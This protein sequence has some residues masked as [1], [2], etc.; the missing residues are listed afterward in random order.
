MGVRREHDVEVVACAHRHIGHP[1][2]PPIMQNAD[3]Q[4][5]HARRR[6]SGHTVWGEA[7]SPSV[8]D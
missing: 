5:G 7:V 1:F 6:Y 2:S 3:P 4:G 8:L